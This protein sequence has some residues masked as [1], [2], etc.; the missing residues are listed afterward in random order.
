MFVGE[1][2]FEFDTGDVDANN[3][4]QI[5]ISHAPP[6]NTCADFIKPG[7]HVGSVDARAII[8]EFQPDAAFSA[9]IHQSVYASG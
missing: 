8:E 1:N 7:M 2:D 6:F 9:H 3:V 5:M 4:R